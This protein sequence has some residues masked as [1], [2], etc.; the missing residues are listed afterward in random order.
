MEKPT[1]YRITKIVKE[2]S[3]VRTIFIN[4]AIKAMPGQFVM[5]WIPGIGEK[6]FALSYINGEQAITVEKKGKTTS[7][8]FK[9]K[10]GDRIGLRGPYGNSFRPD[11]DACIVAGGLGLAP[12]APL[13]ELMP[14][15]YVIYGAKAKGDF[16][17]S[18]RFRNMDCCTDD[19]SFGFRGFVSERLSEVLKKKKFRTVFC[20]GPEP[21]IKEVLRVCEIHNVPMAAS[22]ERYMKC[23]FGICGSCAIGDYLVCKDGPIFSSEKLK[24]IEEFGSFARLKSGRKVPLKDYFDYRDP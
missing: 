19:G 22:L 11:I 20:C 24:S 6:P 14:S 10:K 21:M 23:G 3:R 18:K 15:S 16:I 9:L 12:L 2:N 13:I 17:F 8:M 1:V 4:S 7:A 5:V